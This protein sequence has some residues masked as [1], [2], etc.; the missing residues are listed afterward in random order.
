MHWREPILII[1]AVL[2]GAYLVSKWPSINVIGR[3]LP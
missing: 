1:V 2:I 3:V